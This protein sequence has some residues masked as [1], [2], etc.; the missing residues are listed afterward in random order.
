MPLTY[1]STDIRYHTG[2]PRMQ[3]NIPAWAS[4]GRRFDRTR[5]HLRCASVCPEW[6][7]IKK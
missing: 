5:A 2:I 3:P 7:D 1:A 6:H 4:V